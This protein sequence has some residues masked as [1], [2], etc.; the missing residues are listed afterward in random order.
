MLKFDSANTQ[1]IGTINNRG[2][3]NIEYDVA[4]AVKVGRLRAS[5]LTRS[6]L[7]C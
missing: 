3:V 7:V 5:N 6:P 4:I 2:V 1:L